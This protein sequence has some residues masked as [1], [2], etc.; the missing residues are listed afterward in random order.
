MG[1]SKRDIDERLRFVKIW[2]NYM[3]KNPNKEWSR[4]QNIL[5]NSVI[6]SVIKSANQDAGLCLRVKKAATR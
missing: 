5:I 6:N 3:K 2:V 1:S 4:Q